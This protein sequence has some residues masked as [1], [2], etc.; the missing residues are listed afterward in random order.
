MSKTKI[1][2]GDRTWNPLTGCTIKSE[3]CVNCWAATMAK[4]LRAMGRPEYQD[5]VDD[6]GHWTGLITIVPERLIEP[7]TWRKPQHVL[8]EFMGDLFHEKVNLPFLK[9]IFDV[10]KETRQ[11]VYQ[12]LTK[13]PENMKAALHFSVY[14]PLPNVILGVSIEN[15]KRADERREFMRELSQAGWRTWVSYEPALG[16]VD[17]EGWE[18]LNQLVCGGE[19]GP[20][21][22]AMHPDWARSARDFCQKHHIQFFFKQWGEYAPLDHLVWVTD[23]TTFSH[24]PVDLDGVTMCRVGKGLAGHM[25][26]GREWNEM[27]R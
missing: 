15:Q 2:Y 22:R 23:K 5:V 12:T 26:D 13:R 4:R 18:F 25:L 7:L 10:M 16:N 27:P 8:V 19:S 3:G 24:K 9:N 17:W 20:R 11:H 21:A 1:E 6:R 14:A